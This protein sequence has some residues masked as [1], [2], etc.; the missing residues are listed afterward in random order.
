MRAVSWWVTLTAGGSKKVGEC[1]RDWDWD[2][3]RE[4]DGE[5]SE[6]DEKDM[7]GDGLT[8]A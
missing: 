6:L 2:W 3:L 8:E 4:R 1:E 5:Y 7:M